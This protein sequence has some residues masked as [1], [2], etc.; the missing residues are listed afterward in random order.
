LSTYLVIPDG[1]DRFVQF[2]FGVFELVDFSC[3]FG[4][5]EF[6]AYHSVHRESVSKNSNKMTGNN[7]VL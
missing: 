5:D 7:K 3:L 4:V 2:S 6:Y 1:C